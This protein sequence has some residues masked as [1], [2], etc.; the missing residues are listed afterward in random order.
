MSIIQHI[1]FLNLVGDIQSI[2]NGKYRCETSG[3]VELP[4]FIIP[5]GLKSV[6][7]SL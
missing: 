1:Q 4:F 7:H 5:E 2:G 3:I 6:Y